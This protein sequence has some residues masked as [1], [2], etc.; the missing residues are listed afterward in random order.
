MNDLFWPR[1]SYGNFIFINDQELAVTNFQNLVFY[2]IE[3]KKFT[4]IKGKEY[5]I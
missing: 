4:K 2:N 5:S 3:F 1:L